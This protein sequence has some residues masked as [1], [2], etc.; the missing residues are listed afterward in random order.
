MEPAHKV[1]PGVAVILISGVTDGMMV[2][3]ALPAMLL[4]QP[5]ILFVAVT[6]YTPAAVSRPISRVCPVPA[7]NAPVAALP[8]YNW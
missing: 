7:T 6:V 5:V 2:I 3:V 4:P 1:V 8:L